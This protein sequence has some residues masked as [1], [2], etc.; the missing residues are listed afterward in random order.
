MGVKFCFEEKYELAIKPTH[1]NFYH[2]TWGEINLATISD[3]RIEQLI[4][5]GCPYFKR[6]E[7]KEV[8]KPKTK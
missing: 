5:R 8:A 7:I 3:A 6:K 4:A 1:T 2:S